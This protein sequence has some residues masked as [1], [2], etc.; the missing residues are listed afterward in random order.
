M[1]PKPQPPRRP[2]PVADTALSHRLAVA[3]ELLMRDLHERM[4]DQPILYAFN[5][6][7]QPGP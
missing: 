5:P 7:A 3:R 1:S 4:R 2:F 6:R